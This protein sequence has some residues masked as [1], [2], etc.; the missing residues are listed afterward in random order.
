MDGTPVHAQL[1]TC[2]QGVTCVVIWQVA[3]VQRSGTRVRMSDC[4]SSNAEEAQLD[5]FQSRSFGVRSSAVAE[6]YL[7]AMVWQ[8]AVDTTS[9]VES[10]IGVVVL[11]GVSQ[12]AG[13]DEQAF[14]GRDTTFV[15]LQELVVDTTCT[16]SDPLAT[17]ES[18][19]RLTQTA[20]AAV[21]T[22]LLLPIVWLIGGVQAASRSFAHHPESTS[23]SGLCGMARSARSEVPS[24]AL[25]CLNADNA[26]RLGGCSPWTLAVRPTTEMEASLRADV[27]HVPRLV[28]MPQWLGG[29]VRLL[30]DSRG[31]VANLRIALQPLSTGPP[32]ELQTEL[33][34]QSVGLNF[35]DV[36]NVLGEYP[37]DPGPSGG[38]CAG[39]VTQCD[40]SMSRL[41]VGS[42]VCGMAFDPLASFAQ[43][44]VRLLAHRP[45]ALTSEAACTLPSTW[46]TVHF[47]IGHGE[48]HAAQIALLHAATGGV[49]L[50]ACEYVHW[51]RMVV[52]ATA[53]RPHKHGHLRAITSAGMTGSSRDGLAF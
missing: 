35:R 42:T 5:G 7:F 2:T 16:D 47:A 31:A 8:A 18:A 22:G 41:S 40:Q 53:G 45:R 11:S 43:T 13:D 6:Q 44:D 17:L 15:A 30:F 19:L 12:P 10:A 28:R 9:R 49:G 50:V 34:V 37:G 29:S 51:L 52:S 33:Q 38:D 4:S 20:A 46:S 36:L 1:I 14:C 27:W 48:L 24:A 21:D 26:S 3:T 25:L 23:Q 39:T 32:S